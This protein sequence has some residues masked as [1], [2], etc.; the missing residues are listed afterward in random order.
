MT[1]PL[2]IAAA[3][4]IPLADC[5]GVF[6][7]S[8]HVHWKL[9]V[10][11]DRA[12][13]IQWLWPTELDSVLARCIGDCGLIVAVWFQP[14]N[15]LA[16]FWNTLPMAKR[17]LELKGGWGYQQQIAQAKAQ[18]AEESKPSHLACALLETWA[19]GF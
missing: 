8:F 15:I 12:S 2:G 19:W 16:L 6:L 10:A 18:E 9:L 5:D 7:L 1:H 11:C 3:W 17:P 14:T 4:E 13:H